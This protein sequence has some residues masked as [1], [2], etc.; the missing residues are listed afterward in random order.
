MLSGL[1]VLNKPFGVTFS[2]EGLKCGQTSEKQPSPED[3]VFKKQEKNQVKKVDRPYITS[4]IANDSLS[5][6]DALPYLEKHFGFDKL[7]ICRVPSK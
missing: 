4:G 6:H 1:L 2:R 3:L 5:L 7:H